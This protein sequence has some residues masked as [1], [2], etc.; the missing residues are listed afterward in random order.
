[1][2]IV[3]FPVDVSRSQDGRIVR[4]LRFG[5]RMHA[6]VDEGPGV[7]SVWL[8]GRNL[9]KL[10]AVGGQFFAGL[11]LAVGFGVTGVLADPRL[12]LYSGTNLVAANDKLP[13]RLLRHG[14]AA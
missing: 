8:T 2:K 11:A 13:G 10:D 7:V 9:R 6:V 12:Q 14:R 4:G 5:L 3:G 1:M